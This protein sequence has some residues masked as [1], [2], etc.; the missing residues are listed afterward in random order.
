MRVLIQNCDTL[1]FVGPDGQWCD[2]PEK[3]MDF[4]GTV[5]ALHALARTPTER[6]RILLSFEVHVPDVPLNV[7]NF[8]IECFQAG[9]L[10]STNS[11]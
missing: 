1:K 10:T 7:V 3:A 9:C 11:A 6:S 2:D 5:N 4:G 8:P